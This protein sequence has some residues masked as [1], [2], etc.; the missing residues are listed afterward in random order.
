[1]TAMRV[2][3]IKQAAARSSAHLLPRDVIDP[4]PREG[5]ESHL[6]RAGPV[7]SAS[8]WVGDPPTVQLRLDLPEK[9]RASGQP[10]RLRQQYEVLMA[11][12]LPD[13]FVIAH[14]FEIEIGNQAKVVEARRFSVDIVAPP[15][16]IRTSFDF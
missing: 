12:Q 13:H 8:I 15:I 11:V 3:R 10:P 6:K 7:D 2:Q 16:D 5:A 14:P 1:M 4:N 9:F